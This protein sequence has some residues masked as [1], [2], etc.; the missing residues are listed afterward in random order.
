MN[1]FSNLTRPGLKRTQDKREQAPD[2][3]QWIKCPTTGELIYKADLESA[4]WV[5]P[6]GFHMRIG[7]L[8]RFR[9]LFDD[10]EWTLLPLPAA[11]EDP[12]GFKDDIKYVDRLRK[13]RAKLEA[14]IGF[15]PPER[16]KKPEA[17]KT[18]P[19]KADA[20]IAKP[21]CMT[22]AHGLIGGRKAVVLVQDFD[23]MG[24]SLGM[25]AG[26]AF[27]AAALEAVAQKAAFII[28][29]ASGGAR[30]QEGM[31][32]LMQMPRT[33]LAIQ[34]LRA[35]GLPYIVIL[36]DPTSG[37]VT[38]SYA[39]LGD[40]H[41]AEP[42]AMIAFSGPRVIEKTIRQKLPEGFQR[43]EY[44]FDKGMVDLV[45]P[46][47]EHRAVIGKLLGVMMA[48]TRAEV[49]GA[50]EPVIR[51]SA[52]VQ[53]LPVGPRAVVLGGS[54]EPRRRPPQSQAAE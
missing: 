46:R 19:K 4:H 21:D 1:W 44:L 48:R 11:P 40:V 52:G 33:T 41:I 24:G 16:P 49:R 37:G 32:S 3:T 12:L 6:S 29:T 47:K 36:T 22:A 20:R 14:Q 54:Q 45:V 13:A 51:P 27:V 53:P 5:T 2:A 50:L 35:A 18:D 10:G 17:K 9:S 38:A 31:F 43:A 28:A 15:K 39:M 23:F 8:P 30:M 34:S 7:A 42:G 26:E 25:A